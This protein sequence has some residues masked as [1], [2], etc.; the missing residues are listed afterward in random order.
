VVTLRLDAVQLGG[1]ARDAAFLGTVRKIC[2][3]SRSSAFTSIPH[4]QAIH[5]HRLALVLVAVTFT[6]KASR[7]A[8]NV[9]RNKN[10]LISLNSFYLMAATAYSGGMPGSSHSPSPWA[11]GVSRSPRSCP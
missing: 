5:L 3:A 8:G 6:G 2:S 7:P 9:L 1:G 4:E 11:S 10:D